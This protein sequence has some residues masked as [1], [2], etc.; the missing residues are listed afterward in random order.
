MIASASDKRLNPLSKS[1]VLKKV[2]ETFCILMH[3]S[4]L[5]VVVFSVVHIS[6]EVCKEG[7]EHVVAL[8]D[9]KHRDELLIF[10]DKLSKFIERE[11]AD[12]KGV[13]ISLGKVGEES[14]LFIS[15]SMLLKDRR[16]WLAGMDRN[17]QGMER[18]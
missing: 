4:C 17:G 3:L 5:A 1:A 8:N 16:G 2:E 12:I 9:F 14:R 15:L 11:G 18:D 6:L 10:H 7:K 13:D